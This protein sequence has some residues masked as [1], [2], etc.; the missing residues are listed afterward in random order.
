M[1]RTVLLIAATLLAAAPVFSAESVDELLAKVADPDKRYPAIIELGKLGAAAR[2]AIPAL[3]KIL[4]TENSKDWRDW[5]A[6]RDAAS[7]I[8]KIDPSD[9]EG[10]LLVKSLV[11][12]NS[13]QSPDR[14]RMRDQVAAAS[15]DGIGEFTPFVAEAVPVLIGALGDSRIEV[16]MS[17]ERQLIRIDYPAIEALFEALANPRQAEGAARVLAYLSWNSKSKDLVSREYHSRQDALIKALESPNEHVRYDVAAALRLVHTSKAEEALEQDREREDRLQQEIAENERRKWQQQYASIRDVNFP[18]LLKA[19]CER[20]IHIYTLEY[21]KLT[22]GKG[23]Q[24]VLVASTCNTGTAGPDIHSVYTLDPER[25]VEELK[26][27]EPPR[28]NLEALFGNVNYSVKIDDGTLIAV[29]VD[30]SERRNPLTVWYRWDGTR[31]V[32]G[33]VTQD[34]PYKTSYDCDK[35]R[36]EVE[37]AICYAEPLA[38]LDR[39]LGETYRKALEATSRADQT[40]L[41]KS[42]L[43]WLKRRDTTCGIYKWWVDCLKKIY[44]ERIKALANQ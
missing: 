11:S 3:K 37:R 40:V 4:R 38:D 22:D 42:Q 14:L 17:A 1:R 23:E 35:A 10:F 2:P 36:Q 29:Y 39:Q 16:R 34:G 32:V 27:E 8:G 20:A 26:V 6:V 9:H 33:S 21:G 24:A 18:E 19:E 30:T 15:V 25:R 7:A 43:E 12:Q 5:A 28:K 13:D 44:G 31:F 41:K